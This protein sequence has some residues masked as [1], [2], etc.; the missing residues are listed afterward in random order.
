MW[1][2]VPSEVSAVSEQFP[3]DFAL[4]PPHCIHPHFVQ[5]QA[6][7][8]NSPLKSALFGSCRG[9]R[10]FMSGPHDTKMCILLRE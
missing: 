9:T 1:S 3:P 2:G 8:A 10:N 4:F 7:C 5:F 6:A